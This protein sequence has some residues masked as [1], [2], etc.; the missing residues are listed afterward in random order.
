VR[1]VMVLIREPCDVAAID[2]PGARARHVLVAEDPVA[3]PVAAVSFWVD[4]V[5]DRPLLDVLAGI[6]A[7]AYEVTEHERW[8]DAEPTLSRWVFLVR[9]DG[10]E[11]DDFSRRYEH[12][13]TLARV[14]QPAICR[15]VQDVVTRAITPGAAPF[16]GVSELGFWDRQRMVEQRYGS[17]EGE[18][19]ITADVDRFLERRRS[20]P[21]LGTQH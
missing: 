15:Y 19:V 12:H 3:R 16:D 14:H 5:D 18:A 6:D 20:V 17:A 2:V 8:D 10:L 7:D 13:A 11:R 9:R 1:K 21:V 4:G